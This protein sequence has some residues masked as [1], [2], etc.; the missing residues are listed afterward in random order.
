[1]IKVPVNLITAIANS[2]PHGTIKKKKRKGKIQIVLFRCQ[3]R[4]PRS[5][6]VQVGKRGQA[7]S[8]IGHYSPN[9]YE[10]VL[11]LPFHFRV[12]GGPECQIRACLVSPLAPNLEIFLV[13]FFLIF[14]IFLHFLYKNKFF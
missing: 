6:T 10:R 13:Y 8:L 11:S 3:T 4:H 5:L 14:L 2:N 9:K 12:Y 1:M 7:C